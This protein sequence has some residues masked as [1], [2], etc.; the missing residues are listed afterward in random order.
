MMPLLAGLLLALAFPKFGWW[1]LAWFA[2]G[3]FFWS[4]NRA[5]DLKQALRCGALFAFPFFAITL[6]WLT[7][8]ARFV[9][10]W[11]Y[12]G[13][14]TL[15]LYQTIFFLLLATCYFKLAPFKPRL[16]YPFLL[17]LAWVFI[18]WLR[19]V[20]PF[21]V[22]AGGVGYTQTP[23]LPLIQIASFT[24]VY[25]VSWLVVFFNAALADVAATFRSPSDL[26]L[27]LVDKFIPTAKYWFFS[28]INIW[29]SNAK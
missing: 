29:L 23:C 24:T 22:S 27:F 25:G 19:S 3:P 11:A 10:W 6:F 21:G 9:G 16:F 7:S 12:F 26:R 5:K 17:S 4:L 13:W 1:W 20:G 15:A 28:P 8:L 2:L 14:L 18:E